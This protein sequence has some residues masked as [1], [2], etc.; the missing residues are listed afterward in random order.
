MRHAFKI[1]LLGFILLVFTAPSLY[2]QDTP[3]SSE[4]QELTIGIEKSTQFFTRCV[5]NPIIDLSDDTD[6]AFCACAAANMQVWY[7]APSNKRSN[8]A[9]FG[10]IEVAAPT[11][12]DLMAKIY[13][14]C[15]YIPVYEMTY[16]E[17]Y[18]NTEYQYFLDNPEYL[19]GMCQCLAEGDSIYFEKFAQPFIE[20]KFAE[21][22]VIYDPIEQVKHDNNYY[23]SNRATEDA[24]FME[25]TDNG[26]N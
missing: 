26:K 21:E 3:E 18:Y 24:C 7:D 13:G 19:N 20:M 5:K 9:L 16:E 8:D 15:L 17:C 22:K 12:D 23:H 10:N 1:I 2:A 4:K 6:T 25:Y 14:P 11:E